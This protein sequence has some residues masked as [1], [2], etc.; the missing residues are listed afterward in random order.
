MRTQYLSGVSLPADLNTIMDKLTIL[1]TSSSSSTSH[2]HDHSE[3][4]HARKRRSAHV[5][6]IVQSRVR[7]QA[8]TTETTCYTPAQLITIYEAGEVITSA[9]L[10][11]LCPALVYQKL[12]AQCLTTDTAMKGDAPTTAEK[13]GYGSLAVFIICLCAVLG[14]SLLPCIDRA[15]YKIVMGLFVGLAV[16]TLTGDALLH[17]IPM[18]SHGHSHSLE[19]IV[20]TKSPSDT[21]EEV[22]VQKQ[23]DANK[24]R[25]DKAL[26]V[27]IIMGDAVHNFADGL[28]IGAA[29]SSSVSVGIATSIAVFCHELPHELGDFAVLLRNG[30]SVKRALL[31][32][33]FSS[34]TAFIGLFVGLSVATSEE[35]QTWIFAITAGM[36]LYI[37]LVDLG[38]GV[39]RRP[40]VADSLCP[41]GMWIN[42]G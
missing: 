35:V 12:Y 40:C 6:E 5:P 32:N 4:A 15:I 20:P 33:F 17:L 19:M 18:G 26:S 30:M 38:K 34:L 13:W 37:S 24:Q 23:D 39:G 21:A 9:K 14:V 16:G 27:M 28:A 1:P 22:N 31:W 36:F 7:R 2:D 41:A 10:T 42:C 29:F 8:E 3:E 11:E 25:S